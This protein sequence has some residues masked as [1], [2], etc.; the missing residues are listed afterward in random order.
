MLT[1]L[2]RPGLDLVFCGT[3]AGTD[4]ARR[5]AYYA[6]PGNKFWRTLYRT[7]LTPRQLEPE[8]F[9]LLP[10]F[11]IGLTDLVKGKAGMD[12]E[13]QALEGCVHGGFEEPPSYRA[14]AFERDLGPPLS[15]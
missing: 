9:I 4:S 15:Y 14:G 7:R 1:D 3:A 8:E 6:G 11:G 13:A 10:E 12:H 5:Q 2:L